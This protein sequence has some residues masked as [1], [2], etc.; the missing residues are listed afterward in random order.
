MNQL[1]SLIFKELNQDL[2]SSTYPNAESPFNVFKEPPYKV[3][4]KTGEDEKA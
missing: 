4:D 1:L 3:T 2:H